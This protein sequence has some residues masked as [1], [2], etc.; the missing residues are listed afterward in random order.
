MGILRRSLYVGMVLLVLCSAAYAASKTE[1]AQAKREALIADA[2]KY[3]GSPYVNGATGP[4][5]FDCSGFIY[6]IARKSAKVQLPRSSHAIYRFVEHISDDKIEAGDLLF[7]SASSSG[8]ITHVGLYIGGD[9]MIHAASDGPKTGVIVSSWN[10]RYWKTHYVGAG[11]FISSA[12]GAAGAA[13]DNSDKQKSDAPSSGKDRDNKAKG[14]APSDKNGTDKGTPSEPSHKGTS[15]IDTA[16]KKNGGDSGAFIDNFYCSF[17]AAI[18]WSFFKDNAFDA[19]FRG[20]CTEADVTISKWP[21]CPGIGTMIRGY[22]GGAV[23]V[24]LMLVLSPAAAVRIYAGPAV[25][26]GAPTFSGER[27]SVSSFPGVFG[28][29]F[30]TPPLDAGSVSIRFTQD[31][32]YTVFKKRDGSMPSFGDAFCAGFALVTGIRVNLP[33]R[34]FGGKR[35]T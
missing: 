15:K 5:S 14:T 9:K 24:P 21:L 28:I 16:K 26:L 12:K 29:S 3:I 20:V 34:T 6:F 7:F 23:F 8:R 1:T 30:C 35:G 13:S 17:S 32:S 11:R 19:N 2:K 18:D 27:M 33:M 22:E 25:A 10:E 4:E 31:I